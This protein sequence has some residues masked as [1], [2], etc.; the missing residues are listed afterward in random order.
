MSFNEIEQLDKK[1]I[2]FLPIGTIEA[3]GRHLPVGTDSII[4]KNITKYVSLKCRGILGPLINFGPCETLLKFP[5]TITISTH[6][7]E[8]LLKEIISSIV[9]HGFRN[10]CVINGHGGN[11]TAL[12]NVKIWVK[13]NC[14]HIKI[15]FTDWYEMPS[16]IKLKS[17]VSTY[18]GDHADRTETEMMLYIAARLV[19]L[20]KAVDD[21]PVWPD[22]FETLDDYS[23]IMKYAV[24]GFPSKSKLSTADKLFTSV[25]R[26]IVKKIHVF[27]MT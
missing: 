14:P 21:I 23:S 4:A 2:V 6:T 12:N 8:L 1:Q 20:K 16:I 10:I 11:T 17:T 9:S 13:Y 5:G 3:H 24:D 19:K 15:L 7:L 26:D 18:Q 27:F 25:T 22:N